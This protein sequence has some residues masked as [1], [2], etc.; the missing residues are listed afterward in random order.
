MSKADDLRKKM[1]NRATAQTFTPRPSVT[2]QPLTQVEEKP[3][4]TVAKTLK[5]AQ[6]ANTPKP[7]EVKRA[8]PSE[9]AV[10]PIYGKVPTAD[11]R[12]LDHY[13]IDNGKDLSEAMSDAIQALKKKVGNG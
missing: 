12:W 7:V 2:I 3:V 11:K 4:K 13:R 6:K 10:T 8:V 1:N 5:A 9:E